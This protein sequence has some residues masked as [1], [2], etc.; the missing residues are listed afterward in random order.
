MVS[1]L[2]TMPFPARPPVGLPR[3]SHGQSAT[4]HALPRKATGG[5][6]PLEPWSVGCYPWT[7]P[8]RGPSRSPRIGGIARGRGGDTA[9]CSQLTIDPVTQGRRWREKNRP[10]PLFDRLGVLQP[11]PAI[12]DHRH[13]FTRR[14]LPADHQNLAATPDSTP[15]FQSLS[16]SLAE[17][18]ATPAG[19]I[20]A[21][22]NTE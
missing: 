17:G 10:S 9:R 20:D 3:W 6:A 21:D 8:E 12:V 18:P 1:R 13:R 11:P 19:T 16:S 7:L 15:A 22:R 2:P 14:S 5:L 4:H